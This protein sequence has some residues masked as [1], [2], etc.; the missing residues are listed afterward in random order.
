MGIRLLVII[1]LLVSLPAAA[2]VY[3]EG[4]KTR[5]RFA[6][7]ELG[8]E[9]RYLPGLG[10]STSRR[11]NIN[12]LQL[13]TLE[14][15]HETRFIIGGTHFWGH[16][17]FYLG[18]PLSSW[19]GKSFNTGVETGAKFYPWKLL[20]KK[21]RP[22]LGFTINPTHYH[23]GD[24]V[25]QRKTVVPLLGG[26]TYNRS[27]H[28]FELGLSYNYNNDLS[29]YINKEDQV[30]VKVHPLWV[31]FSY[32]LLLETTLGAE[33][34]WLTGS[35]QQKTEQL[36]RRNKLNN[37]SIA[38]GPSSTRFLAKS[39]HNTNTK[40]YLHHPE[41]EKFFW[42]VGI[43]YY[44]HNPD[45]HINLAYRN[46]SSSLSAYGSRQ[47]ISRTSVAL[48]GFKFLFD[49][50]GF[51]PFAG[52]LLSMENIDIIEHTGNAVT[53]HG[54]INSLKLGF[55]VGWDI[56]P[57]RVQAWL[58]RTNIRYFPNLTVPMSS[59]YHYSVDQLELNFIQF[60]LYPER[61]FL[62]RKKKEG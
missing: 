39:E 6:Q 56:R 21:V 11:V 32:K 25:N 37:F 62:N 49:Y 33:K 5:H 48:E 60:V 7:L 34:D 36:A 26:L 45:A 3:Q 38:L 53:A 44:L 30:T 20:D 31:N 28:L 4:G 10:T 13:H 12:Y 18:V 55:I 9:Q 22:Y 47:Q 52:P 16:A 24:G 50:H 59:G 8:L 19:K 1:W 54:G 58:L 42:D 40:P 15:E 2:Q 17:D 29:Y 46:F 57:T 41:V 23:Q 27:Q 35:T 14:D 51:V 61:I 43:G